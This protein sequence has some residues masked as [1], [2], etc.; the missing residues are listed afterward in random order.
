MDWGGA[1]NPVF[2]R[3]IWPSQPEIQQTV[4][5]FLKKEMFVSQYATAAEGDDE[6][7]NIQIPVDSPTHGMRSTYVKK[8]PYFDE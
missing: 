7:K 1:W 8:P 4:T 6:W 3:D 5:D 2:L